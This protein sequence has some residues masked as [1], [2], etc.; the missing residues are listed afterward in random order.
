ME[1]G[2][3]E[4]TGLEELL[5]RAETC[6]EET[7]TAQERALLARLS[8]EADQLKRRK[9]QQM[10]EWAAR[11]VEEHDRDLKQNILLRMMHKVCIVVPT[12]HLVVCVSQIRA[13]S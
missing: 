8:A 13:G 5:Q 6:E 2:N 4:K 7:R 10:Q 11:S 1:G 3:S 12:P 9:E